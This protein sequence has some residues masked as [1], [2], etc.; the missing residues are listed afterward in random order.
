MKDT[1]GKHPNSYN[2]VFCNTYRC[3]S[4]DSI[5]YKESEKYT[6]YLKLGSRHLRTV[7]FP[8]HKFGH[9]DNFLF[10]YIPLDHRRH[11]VDD[12]DDDDDD[13]DGAGGTKQFTRYGEKFFAASLP[14]DREK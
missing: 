6:S 7:R 2:T 8:R 4:H 1:N 9:L 14:K 12:D 5:V 11:L 3:N 10:C 13:D